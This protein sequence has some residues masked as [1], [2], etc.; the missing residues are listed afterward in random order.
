MAEPIRSPAGAGKRQMRIFFSLTA[1]C[2]GTTAALAHSG[3]HGFGAVQALAHLA[4]EPDHLAII[5]VGLAVAGYL[6]K[7]S[8]RLT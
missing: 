6:Y 4:T 3:D 1:F 8:R 5:A 7:R 2:L